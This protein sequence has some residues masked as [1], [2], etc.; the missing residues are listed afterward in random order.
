ML[1]GSD[2]GVY[3]H[4]MGGVALFWG[5]STLVNCSLV[6]KLDIAIDGVQS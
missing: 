6:L 1:P 4:D 3:S 5:W 2:Y